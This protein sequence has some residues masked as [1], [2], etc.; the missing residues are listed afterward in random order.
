M[1]NLNSQ[2]SAFAQQR[3]SILHGSDGVIRDEVLR[4]FQRGLSDSIHATLKRATTY[5][6]IYHLLQ[7]RDNNLKA[8]K[9]TLNS[10]LRTDRIHYLP[11]TQE[12]RPSILM[13]T[14]ANTGEEE[15]HAVEVVSNLP[16]EISEGSDE[17]SEASTDEWTDVRQ[18]SSVSMKRRVSYESR[19]SGKFKRKQKLDSEFSRM[20]KGTRRNVLTAHQKGI[21]EKWI[22]RHLDNPYP[23]KKEKIE[24]SAETGIS[25]RQVT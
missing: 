9:N 14:E 12:Q 24:L 15:S 10:V 18:I 1:L 25:E 21:L 20:S 7:A 23:S 6:M 16:H 4:R 3:L 11:T 22:K 17:T 2:T 13:L 5:L 8:N 19:D